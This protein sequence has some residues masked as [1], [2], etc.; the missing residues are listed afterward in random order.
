MPLIVICGRPCVGKTAFANELRNYLSKETNPSATST[1]DTTNDTSTS[2][3][4]STSNSR[5]ILLNDESLGIKKSAGY[6]SK[7]MLSIPS[8][9]GKEL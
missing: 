5:V 7:F 9:Y 6:A 4:S 1:D 3:S 2:S 8:N